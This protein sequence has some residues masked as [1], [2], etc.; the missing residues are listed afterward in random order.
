MFARVA[1][2]PSGECLGN[3]THLLTKY[4][5]VSAARQTYLLLHFWSDSENFL[6]QIFVISGCTNDPHGFFV[7]AFICVCQRHKVGWQICPKCGFLLNLH[8]LGRLR[9]VAWHS[10]RTSV[11]DRRTFA[12]LRS[13]CGWRVTTYVGKPSALGQPTR[14]TQPF[15]L[16]G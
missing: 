6:A 10:G 3:V 4:G 12:V 9:L 5:L 13:T 7:H 16:S 15:I 11:S 8:Q 1:V 2:A 14:P